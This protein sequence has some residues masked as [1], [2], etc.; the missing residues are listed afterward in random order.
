MEAP[1]SAPEEDTDDDDDQDSEEEEFAIPKTERRMSHPAEESLAPM[2]KRSCASGSL[3]ATPPGVRNP[4]TNR[5]LRS[6]KYF[7]NENLL[8]PS[9]GLAESWA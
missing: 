2:D 3:S 5:S 7:V 6:A 8:S 4:I 9:P 1:K